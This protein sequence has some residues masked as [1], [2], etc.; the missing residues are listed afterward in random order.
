MGSSGVTARRYVHVEPEFVIG[1]EVVIGRLNRLIAGWAN[2]VGLGRVS[3]AYVAVDREATR[4][5]RQWLCSK[6][7]VRFGKFVRFASTRL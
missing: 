6:Q 4:R 5:L 2:Y 1:R 7:K 3:P